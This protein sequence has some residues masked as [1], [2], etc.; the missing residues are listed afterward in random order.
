MKKEEKTMTEVLIEI[1]NA[2][3]RPLPIR[4]FINGLRVAGYIKQWEQIDDS[5]LIYKITFN[6]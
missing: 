6:S 1:M 4:E 5:G 2:E 3:K